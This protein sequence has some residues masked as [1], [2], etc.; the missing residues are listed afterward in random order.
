MK[1]SVLIGV[2]LFL[3]CIFVT[4][5]ICRLKIENDRQV[6]LEEK[7]D[8]ALA[9]LDKATARTRVW[10][11]DLVEKTRLVTS[12]DMYRLLLMDAELSASPK[13]E[14]GEQR[15]YAAELLKDLAGRRGWEDARL[16]S[17]KWG[18]FVAP[19]FAVPLS[20]GRKT[21]VSTAIREGKIVFGPIYKKAG[22][23][24]LDVADPLF[25][26]SE[27]KPSAMAAL[28][29]ALPVDTG[30][31]DIF[32]KEKWNGFSP[33]IVDLKS[34]EVVSDDAGNPVLL[35]CTACKNVRAENLPFQERPAFGGKESVYSLGAFIESPD[36]LFTVEV[37][38]SA[39]N[40]RIAERR[41]HIYLTGVLASLGLALA[42]AFSWSFFT[43]RARKKRVAEL[44][45]L[46]RL[47]RRQKGLLDSVNQSLGAGLV[48]LDK[49]GVIQLC[50]GSFRK[51]FDWLPEGIVSS[52]D[53]TDMPLS[54]LVPDS[55]WEGLHAEFAN[56]LRDDAQKSAETV[57]EGRIY[58]V[59]VFPFRDVSEVEEEPAPQKIAKDVLSSLGVTTPD[60]KATSHVETTSDG[61][62]APRGE[63]TPDG[64]LAPR[65]AFAPDGEITPDGVICIFQ[66]I[67]VFREKAK[68]AAKRQASMVKAMEMSIESIDPNL[69]GHSE[70]LARLADRMGKLAGVSAEERE[71]LDIAARLSQT[72]KLF[73]P[74]ELLF[75][76]G[77][78]TDEER[79][80]MSLSLK[81]AEDML[82]NLSFGVPVPEMFAAIREGG[83]NL[84]EK[85]IFT[86][87]A[88]VAMTSPRAWRKGIPAAEALEAMEKEGKF[89]PEIL[90]LLQKII[91]GDI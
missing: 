17:K 51:I 71:A 89:D 45:T 8:L 15:D 49:N 69:A 41:L 12:S 44:E 21:L 16:W 82:K 80:S 1:K 84:P 19:D 67:T 31:A 55:E 11:D 76:N 24:M 2:F 43:A 3:V 53:L 30:L 78:L 38:A 28:F 48:L 4:N 62:L 14:L 75:K 77:K 35:K 26:V 54:N 27:E 5:V 40:D 52:R 46:N 50:N 13:E 56:T 10:R 85:I 42:G 32:A 90:R 34:G 9:L 64:T 65:G 29:F 91:M 37:P 36:W 70:K 58:R 6:I 18:E 63:I 81:K 60:G 7:R 33:K 73:V 22:R 39:V 57:I 74:R 79:K 25:P 86:A 59:T 68:E 23:L 47:I 72:G 88:F 83:K 66:D 61:T 87:N 20:E